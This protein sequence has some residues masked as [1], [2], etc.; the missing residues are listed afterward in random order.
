M[1]K[2]C[3]LVGRSRLTNPFEFEEIDP[4]VCL[5]R[6]RFYDPAMIHPAEMVDNRLIVI[7]HRGTRHAQ[8]RHGAFGPESARISGVN[9][10]PNQPR[11]SSTPS[12]GWP[13]GMPRPVHSPMI[14][15]ASTGGKLRNS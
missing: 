1:F 6:H 4:I 10:L 7:R 5:D 15:R 11:F 8:G 13:D 12:K 2:A 3:S 9:R 14:S